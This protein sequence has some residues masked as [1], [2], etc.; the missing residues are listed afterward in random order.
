MSEYKR[1]MDQ[2]K[3]LQAQAD[4]AWK[5]Q[6]PEMVAKARALVEEFQI[7]PAELFKKIP[8]PV[9]AKYSDGG[10][11]TWSGRG[12][13]PVWLRERIESGEN[14]EDFLIK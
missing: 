7:K 4:Q 2:I 5:E 14:K 8:K 3:D 9:K 6:R 10:V 13:T 12:L 1:I 11:N